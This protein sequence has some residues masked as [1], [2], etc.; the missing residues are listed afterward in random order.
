MIDLHQPGQ[1]KRLAEIIKADIDAYCQWLYDDGFRTHLGASVIGKECLR[2]I[3]YGYRWA[4]HIKFSGRIL[5][6]FNRGHREEIRFTEWLI[7]IGNDVSALTEDGNQHRISAV[8]GHFGGSLDSMLQLAARYNIKQNVLLGEFKTHNDNSFK[9]LQ[10]S[11]VR[12]T[13]PSHYDQMCSYGSERRLEFCLYCAINKNDDDLYIEIVPLD[14]PYGASLIG[15]A[16][17]IIASQTPPPRIAQSEAFH[18]CKICDHLGVCF[19]GQPLA[20][21]CRSCVY[22]IPGAAKSWHCT[23]PNHS[24]EIPTDFI[25][26]GCGD[27]RAIA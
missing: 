14:W 19:R 15:K 1:A 22:A 3:W 4:A 20:I 9:K 26:H 25:P 2:D 18:V 17:T 7:G 27:H 10:K 6:L 23:H 24:G 5:R 8:E 16:H 21:N 11:G 12:L 13:K